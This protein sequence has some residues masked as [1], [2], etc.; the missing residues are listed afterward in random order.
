MCCRLIIANQ[1]P[2]CPGCDWPVCHEG[3]IG[4]RDPERHGNECFILS[5]RTHRALDGLHEYYR[6]SCTII[7]LFN[8]YCYYYVQARHFIGTPLFT[9]ATKR[10]KEVES[11]V[12][13]AIAHGE[14]RTRHRN[15]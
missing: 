3:C 5:L 4:L 15:T 8:N 13:N 7:Y 12:R 9:F 6:Y 14:A 11:T 2:R 10:Y 1:S